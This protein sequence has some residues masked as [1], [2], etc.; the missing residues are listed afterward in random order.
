MPILIALPFAATVPRSFSCPLRFLIRIILRRERQFFRG[1]FAPVEREGEGGGFDLVEFG[2]FFRD[3]GAQL[4]EL[5][6]RDHDAAF[7]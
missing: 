2:D 4:G 7:H 6:G 1:F 5:A 3:G